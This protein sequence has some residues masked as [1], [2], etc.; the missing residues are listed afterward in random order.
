MPGEA[1]VTHNHK[2]FTEIGQ[3]KLKTLSPQQLLKRIGE[4]P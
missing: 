4:F 2:D 1:I 3:F